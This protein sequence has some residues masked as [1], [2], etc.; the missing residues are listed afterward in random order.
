M[1]YNPPKIISFSFHQDLES[2]EISSPPTTHQN[3]RRN[4]SSVEASSKSQVLCNIGNLRNVKLVEG[5]TT[6]LIS[7]SKLCDDE[8][9][10]ICK[11]LDGSAQLAGTNIP[12]NAAV[13]NPTIRAK[14]AKN[15]NPNRRSLPIRCLGSKR[16]RSEHVRAK[17]AHP[18]KMAPQVWAPKHESHHDSSAKRNHFMPGVKADNPARIHETD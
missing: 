15:S 4:S 18:G 5:L 1:N 12:R 6:N 2:L 11:K 13:G 16:T 14:P 3:P 8:N 10:V 7:E 17:A 9:I